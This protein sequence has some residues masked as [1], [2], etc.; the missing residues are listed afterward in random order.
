M[1]ITPD[2]WKHFFVGIVIGGI[3]QAFFT[4]LLDGH[5]TYSLLLSLIFSFAIGYGFELFS[6]YT[7]KG[8][9]E[10]MDAVAVLVGA[11]PGIGVVYLIQL[12]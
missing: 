7:G 11:I 6:K 10:F 3:L 12:F 5:L 4:F 9:Y 2:K 1:K 8:H